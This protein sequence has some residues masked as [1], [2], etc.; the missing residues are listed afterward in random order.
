MTAPTK[1]RPVAAAD[2]KGKKGKD[3][4]AEDGEEKKGGKLK[5]IIIAVVA[6]LG[7]GAG[8]YFFVFSGSGDEAEPAP[9]AGIEVPIDPITINLAGGG[10]LKVGVTLQLTEDAGEEA[11]GTAKASDVIIDMFSEAQPTDVTGNRDAM[12]AELEQRIE[13]AYNTEEAG[14][15]VMGIYY[16]QYVTQ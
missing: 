7:I 4:P 6:L 16:T 8:L 10:Y 12:K 5:L 9:V 15:V 2:S 11:P 1:E 3:A 14:D 13:D